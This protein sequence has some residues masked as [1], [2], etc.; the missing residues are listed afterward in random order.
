MYVTDVCTSLRAVRVK[1][2]CKQIFLNGISQKNGELDT[3]LEG[4][5]R[6]IRVFIGMY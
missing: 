4:Q 6:L 5:A 2:A 1:R 3:R